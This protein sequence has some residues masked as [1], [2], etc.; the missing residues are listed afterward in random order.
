M[1]EPIESI[2]TLNQDMEPY[3]IQSSATRT[4]FFKQIY[5]EPYAPLQFV[6][7]S[8]MHD[9]PE[10]WDRMVAYV[11]HYSDYISFAIHTGD[12]CGN[13]QKDYADCYGEGTP[14][15]RPIF[16]CV[17]NHDTVYYDGTYHPCTKKS[18]HDLLFNHTENWDATFMESPDSMTY[19][20]DF[21]ESGI[22]LIV[23]DLYYDKEAQCDWLRSV[24]ADAKEKDLAVVSAMHEATGNVENTYD[25][26]F[27]T[28]NDYIPLCGKLPQMVFEPLFVQF[29]EAGGCYICNLAGHEHHDLFGLT[30]AGILN[31]IVPCATSWAGWSDGKRVRGTRTY[32]CF[33]VMCI[34][35]NLGI[36]KLV[37]IGDQLDHYLRTKRV[38]C[39]DYVH[40]K[41]I[42]NS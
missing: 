4:A 8:D 13:S 27:H 33:N 22:R 28:Y 24:L 29:R 6:H 25:V 38:L 17:G 39:F 2:L 40:G 20:R 34:D 35:R 10:L 3:V 32:D 21:P 5:P 37:R 30:E 14:C 19:Y 1:A 42:S 26:T 18:A 7:L 31:V 9:V 36:L 23:L 15:V 12:Y 41:V 16:N 11:N